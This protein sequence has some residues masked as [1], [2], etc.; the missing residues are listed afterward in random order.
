MWKVPIMKGYFALDPELQKKKGYDYLYN[1]YSSNPVTFSS[2]ER[3]YY[4]LV[5][6]S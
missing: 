2:V 4:K 5:R 1:L 3:C 6:F